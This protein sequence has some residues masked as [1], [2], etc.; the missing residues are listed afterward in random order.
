MMCA[1][2]FEVKM[3]LMA[4]EDTKTDEVELGKTSNGKTKMDNGE[5]KK[6]QTSDRVKSRKKNRKLRSKRKSKSHDLIA[7]DNCIKNSGDAVVSSESARDS[8]DITPGKMESSLEML[9][10]KNDILVKECAA[11]GKLE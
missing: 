6:G 7:E 3:E 9:E 10:D 11:L 2:D 8:N 1:P 5:E 4:A